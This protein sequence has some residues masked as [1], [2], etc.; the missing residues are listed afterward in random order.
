MRINLLITISI[1]IMR[2]TSR[3]S[4]E[5]EDAIGPRRVKIV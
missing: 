2:V 3:F 4:D 1:T 5:F